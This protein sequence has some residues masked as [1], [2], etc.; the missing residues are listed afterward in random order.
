MAKY[1][2]WLTGSRNR[3]VAKSGDATSGLTAKVQGWTFGA[4]VVLRTL[5][6]RDHIDIYLTM[7]SEGSGKTLIYTGDDL[8]VI[9]HVKQHLENVNRINM[10]VKP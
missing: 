4:E 2:G 1:Y 7:G 5:K 3:T 10:E 8:S 6:G 9:A